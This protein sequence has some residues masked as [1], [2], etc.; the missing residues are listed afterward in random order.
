[1]PEAVPPEARDLLPQHLRV[2]GGALPELVASLVANASNATVPEETQKSIDHIMNVLLDP[3]DKT[4]ING[5]TTP[6]GS[7][8][9]V[10]GTPERTL[11]RRLNT[12]GQAVFA[13][14]RCMAASVIAKV[15]LLAGQG[16]L[17]VEAVLTDIL[18]DET[19]L[20]VRAQSERKPGGVFDKR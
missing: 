3:P 15:L 1:M 13:G 20:V 17:C 10:L 2:V 6:I 9:R 19:P 7:L 5:N 11:R 12:I 16:R 4:S 14:S 18:Y 8:V